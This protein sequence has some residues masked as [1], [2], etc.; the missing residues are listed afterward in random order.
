[1][2]AADTL[3]FVDLETTGGNPAYDRITE[4]G[5]VRVQNGELLE[6]WSSLVNP[7]CPIS[8]YI[9]AFT[10]IS[11]EMVAD[12]P[13]FADVAAA[14]F[15]KLRGA[16]FI[17]HNARFDHSFL[18]TEFRKAGHGLFRG[19]VVHGQIVA[20]LI[21]RTRAPQFGCGDRTP[22]SASAAPDTARSEMPG[23]SGT[24]GASCSAKFLRTYLPQAAAHAV[25]S[26]PKLPPQLPPGLADEL[27]ESPGVYRFL[28][29]GRR[30]AVHRQQQLAARARFCPSSPSRA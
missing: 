22:W 2:D 13:L 30:A 21:P 16:V 8:P 17:A 12:A 4:I 6:E 11:S 3:A 29:R 14:V 5:I 28:W 25:L 19:R 23:C 20:P 7:E 18:R 26:H 10:G 15:E 24:C 1:M 27:P 9:E